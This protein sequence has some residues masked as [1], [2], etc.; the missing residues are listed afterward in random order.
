MKKNNLTFK[1]IFSL[2]LILPMLLFAQEGTK[3]VS[4]DPTKLSGLYYNPITLY[5]SYLNAPDDNNISFVISDFTKERFYFGFSWTNYGNAGAS[6]QTLNYS[7]KNEYMYYRILNSSGTVV[8]GPTL[9][10][11]P[12]N[13]AG[14]INSYAEAIA[15]PRIGTL[16]PGG[17]L[18]IEFTPP[19]NGN[20]VIQYWRGTSASN[21]TMNN[22]AAVS[23]LFDFT[24]AV[25]S[26]VTLP[27]SYTFKPGRVYG[28]K[29]GLVTTKADSS[30][31]YFTDISTV[32]S[33]GF[34]VYTDANNVLKLELPDIQPLAYTIG[35]NNYGVSDT[36][37]FPVDRQSINSG[38]T[39]PS[40]P[41]GF[42]VFLNAPDAALF[43]Y[44]TT[45]AA[46]PSFNT[47]IIA[48]AG[49]CNTAPYNINFV[50]QSYGDYRIIIKG[51]GYTDRILYYYGL[52]PGSYSMQWDGKDGAGTLIAAATTLT[53]ELTAF[54]DRFNVPLFDIEK[55]SG[56]IKVTTMAPAAAQAS[57]LFWDDSAL[58][59]FNTG[60]D[61]GN[62]TGAGTNN[63]TVGT[64]SPAHNWTV[65]TGTN[66]YNYFG[67]ARTINS[68]GYLYYQTITGT[69]NLLC[70]DVTLT[71]TVDNP[72]PTIGNNVVFTLTA[73]NNT[74]G[75]T[76]GSVSVN[77]ILPA[78]FTYVSSVPSVG[79]ITGPAP[80]LTWNLG[81]LTNGTPRTAT[82]TATVKADTHYTNVATISTVNFETNYNN[83]SAAVKVTPAPLT[84]FT[85]TNICPA[86]DID[87]VPPKG[88]QLNDLHFGTVPPGA[89][90][91]WFNNAGHTGSALSNTFITSSGSYYAFYY[92][93]VGN[94]YSPASAKVNILIQDCKCRKSPTLGTP[95]G[96]TKVGIST[97]ATKTSTWPEN[98]ANG[99]IA[100]ESTNK[101]FVITRTTTASIATPVK[102]MLIYD[103]A[104][105][106]FSLYN[107]TSWHCIAQTC[108]E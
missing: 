107:G 91:V 108:N 102:G 69:S 63:S 1:W 15:G 17:Y 96:Y 36:N 57:N 86:V 40:L 59:A 23:P 19:A 103:T 24:V 85:A 34:Y 9:L 31:R 32:G 47:S 22:T 42:N 71:K 51:S 81:N 11:R 12:A 89:S 76:A 72:T 48:P 73:S 82:I 66:Y 62:N 70:A 37:N 35:V 106:C 58:T 64:P 25:P 39:S 8:A 87:V 44:N 16:N 38:D 54:S 74:T 79:T 4:Q 7:T 67:N 94:C 68:W 55:N 27:T 105:N 97:Q 98:V 93:S 65:G 46:P 84:E 99:F 45:Q 6:D 60:N 78:G 100:L 52:N 83:N 92:D 90:L 53:F 28:A 18:P 3:Q 77:D 14:Q 80:N 101:G 10:P 49:A 21:S 26:P 2:I 13:S 5:G 43:P 75:S 95:D 20:Y 29:W 30:A 56:G 61:N 50:T 88:V 41:G 104:N 33:P